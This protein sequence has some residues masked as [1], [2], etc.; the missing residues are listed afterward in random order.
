MSRIT[1]GGRSLVSMLWVIVFIS[2]GGAVLWWMVSPLLRG[3]RGFGVGYIYW[4]A[5]LVVWVVY[6]A[7]TR[8]FTR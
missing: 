2:I 1:T 5:I 3:F 6:V 7:L 4:C 8:H